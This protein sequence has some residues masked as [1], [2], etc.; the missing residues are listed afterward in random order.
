MNSGDNVWPTLGAGR[1]YG[2]KLHTCKQSNTTIA[3]TELCQWLIIN[4][5]PAAQQQ[6]LL[7]AVSC[8]DLERLSFSSH[9]PTTRAMPGN[10]YIA[11]SRMVDVSRANHLG[12]IVTVSGLQEESE[13]RP[14]HVDKSLAAASLARSFGREMR[15]RLQVHRKFAM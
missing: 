7:W 11:V 5:D 12:V 2:A 13:D 8:R 4:A 6:R 1:A 15:A 10:L 14:R 9:T 3:E